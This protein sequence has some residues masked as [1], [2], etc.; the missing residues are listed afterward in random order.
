M[1]PHEELRPHK[2]ANHIDWRGLRTRTEPLRTL[3]TVLGVRGASSAS[4]ALSDSTNGM[5][6]HSRWGYDVV[7]D[8]GSIIVKAGTAFIGDRVVWE[9]NSGR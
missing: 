1:Q 8:F 3:R 9:R 4:E 5:L 7:N 2:R 6:R